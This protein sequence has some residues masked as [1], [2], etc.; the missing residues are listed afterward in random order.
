MQKVLVTM[1]I[2]IVLCGCQKSITQRL[3]SYIESKCEE[4]G[5][6]VNLSEFA[7]FDWDTMYVFDVQATS[8]EMSN[9]LGY[10]YN[11]WEDLKS[12]VVFTSGKKI[13]YIEYEDYNPDKP[14][15]ISFSD[16][17]QAKH[18]M[19]FAHDKSTFK[20]TRVPVEENCY[21]LTTN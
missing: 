6:V 15:L 20:V 5:C 4:G 16:S 21:I 9:A 7:K 8:E 10:P 17:N 1:I 18:V 11:G 3:G 14:S 19:K 2:L 13:V 12:Q